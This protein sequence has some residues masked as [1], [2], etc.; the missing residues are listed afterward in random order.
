MKGNRI[1]S[2]LD[3][4]LT[5]ITRLAFV[6]FLW[7]LFSILGLFVGGIFPAT[8]AALG[9]S[10]KW[11]MSER[12]IPILKTFKELY[13]RDFVASNILGWIL[14]LIG[15]LLYINFRVIL[16]LEDEVFVAVPFAFYLLLFFYTILTIWSFPLLSHYNGTIRQHLKNSII[17]GISKIHHTISIVIIL[18]AISYFSLEF[19]GVIPFFSISI[20]MLSWAWISFKTFSQIDN[21]NSIKQ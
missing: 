14:T 4:I 20:I 21:N 17:I 7:I 15:I 16:N 5:W 2:L 10:R 8:I 19:P 3:T 13:R 11:L 1:V 6:N 18:F 12:D 9:V